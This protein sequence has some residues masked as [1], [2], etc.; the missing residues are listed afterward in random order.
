MTNPHIG[1]VGPLGAFGR[2]GIVIDSH[3]LARTPDG[4]KL[5]TIQH[6]LDDIE[7][8]SFGPAVRVTTQLQPSEASLDLAAATH[9]QAHPYQGQEPHR[10]PFD[11]S[12]ADKDHGITAP[13]FA[14]RDTDRATTPESGPA[15]PGRSA[16]AIRD[17]GRDP[18]DQRDGLAVADEFRPNAN[19]VAD[20]GTESR[21]DGRTRG[22]EDEPKLWSHAEATRPSEQETKDLVPPAVDRLNA[23][24]A[25]ERTAISEPDLAELQPHTATKA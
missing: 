3:T 18:I 24:G 1:S 12:R 7:G 9:L 17:A 2:A 16:Q 5:V 8:D 10:G 21:V 22:S 14:G 11:P 6:K 15:G 19:S 4:R 25:Y 20:Y 23:R 13:T